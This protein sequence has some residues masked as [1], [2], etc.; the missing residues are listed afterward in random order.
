MR[1]FEVIPPPCVKAM[2][3]GRWTEKLNFFFETARMLRGET[4]TSPTW[5]LSGAYWMATLIVSG[6]DA[7]R[8]E[9]GTSEHFDVV[10]Y[11]ITV[12]RLH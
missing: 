10:P 9:L 1:K 6:E 2:D 12:G 8:K 7:T 11:L 4:Y 3:Y 5:V